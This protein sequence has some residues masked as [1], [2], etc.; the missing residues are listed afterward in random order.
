MEFRKEDILA[1]VL[2]EYSR[3][4]KLPAVFGYEGVAAIGRKST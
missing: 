4:Q 2:C 3:D 1:V